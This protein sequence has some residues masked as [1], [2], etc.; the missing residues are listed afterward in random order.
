MTRGAVG[1]IDLL[2]A[3]DNSASMADKQAILALAIP[4]LIV[5]LVNPRCLDDV[6]SAPVATQPMS[7]LDPCPAGSTRDFTPVL[8]IHVGMISSS[9]GSFG[10]DGCPL[11]PDSSCP[12]ADTTP[13]DNQGHLVT[14]SDTCDTKGPVPTYQNLGFL[15]WDPAQKVSPPGQA[16]VGDPTTTPTTPGL[17][18]SLHDSSWATGSTVAASNRRTKPGIAF[19]ST[20]RPTRRSSW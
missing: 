10:A 1:K 7:P 19:W 8:D 9:L 3:L 16:A 2:L 18:T 12:S 4:D 11:K 5:G 14:R 15:A 17:A 13:L 20:R 6:T